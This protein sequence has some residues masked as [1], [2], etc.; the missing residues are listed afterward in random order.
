M[1]KEGRR[2]ASPFSRTLTLSDRLAISLSRLCI[3]R[4]AALSSS[5][6]TSS[7]GVRSFSR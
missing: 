5:E 2:A 6:A 7:I 4:A 1:A 3:S